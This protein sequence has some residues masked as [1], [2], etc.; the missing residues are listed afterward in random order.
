MSTRGRGGPLTGLKVVE[1]AGGVAVAVAGGL[2]SDLGADVLLVEPRDESPL[3]ARPGFQVWARGKQS[4]AS[5]TPAAEAAR[6]SRGADLLLG[7]EAALGTILGGGATCVV[8]GRDLE[9]AD[10]PAAVA[11]SLAEAWTG[12]AC[13]QRGSRP[14]PF[15]VRSE[16]GAVGTGLLAALASLVAVVGGL[17]EVRVTHLAGALTMQLFTA[18]A[19]PGIESALPDG[20]GDPRRLASPMTRFFEASDGWLVLAAVNP[21]FWRKLCRALDMEDLLDDPRYAAGPYAIADRSDRL[22]LVERVQKRIASRT[23]A[24]WIPWL[25]ER[26]VITAPVLPPGRILDL[27]QALAAGQ[28]LTLSHPVHGELTMPAPVHFFSRSAA[29]EAVSA[30]ELG[31]HDSAFVAG[32]LRGRPARRAQLAWPPLQGI[33]VVDVSTYAAGPGSARLLAA[34][35]AEVVKVEPPEGDPFRR[36]GFSYIGVNRGKRGLVL[37]LSTPG[38]RRQ[39]DTLLAGAD[40]LVHNVRH[41][42]REAFGLSESELERRHPRLLRCVIEGF[43]RTGPDVELPAIDVVLEALSGG[44]LVQGGG[45]PTGYDG[46]LVD[47]AAALLAATGIVAGL[48]AARDGTPG[49]EVVL[50]LL[51]ATMHRHCEHLVRPLSHWEP[52]AYA[53]D[54]VGP[55]PDHRLYR[56]SDG[57]LLLAA[58][59]AALSTGL[60][61]RL[62]A[63]TVGAGVEWLRAEGLPCAPAL[64][65]REF[66][67]RARAAGDPLVEEFDDPVWGRLL[68][69]G[70]FAE[71]GDHPWPTLGSA[72]SLGTAVGSS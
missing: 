65:A 55:G 68:A 51:G 19:S 28:V 14:G 31:A 24:E 42:S 56:A 12:L 16:A 2:L 3:R 41:S 32:L 50:S 67:L 18:V 61:A 5:S 60:E 57:W 47:N 63:G 49:Q 71:F 38:G 17:S 21:S 13:S 10:A 70:R 30:P 27:P 72:P 59:G 43:G 7:D 54:P 4:L 20:D 45:S 15:F 26:G 39:L 58:P 35:G 66:L 36:I 48:R 22:A 33:K 11:G 52:E 40:V 6:L 62:A 9:G 46:G 69:L 34:L 8:S 23:V 37:D 53:P 44:P 64:S 1:L 25:R 29:P